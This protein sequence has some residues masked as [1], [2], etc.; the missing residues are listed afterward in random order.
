MFERYDKKYHA[1][2]K[3]LFLALREI[4]AVRFKSGKGLRKKVGREHPGTRRLWHKSPFRA[5]RGKERGGKQK[6]NLLKLHHYS[7]EIELFF[8]AF[9][10]RK[11]E[12]A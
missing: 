10:G 9:E 3:E 7:Y 2:G 8:F 1:G 11:R 4:M 6:R 12:G 5:I